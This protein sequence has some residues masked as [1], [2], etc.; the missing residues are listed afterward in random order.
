MSAVRKGKKLFGRKYYNKG[1]FGKRWSE[2]TKKQ[3]RQLNEFDIE[4]IKAALLK[5]PRYQKVA[6][7]K[8]TK[9]K[10]DSKKFQKYKTRGL[11][12]I[13]ERGSEIWVGKKQI[14]DAIFKP[15]KKSKTSH[16]ALLNQAFRQLVADEVK[17]IRTKKLRM[18][19]A[20]DGHL[21]PLSGV[22]L[23]ECEG[24][25]DLDHVYPFSKMV[26]DF[27]RKYRIIPERL[28]CKKVGTSVII[29]DENI[30]DLWIEYHNT[31][32]DLQLTCRKANIKKSNKVI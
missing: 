11:I 21:C 25:V 18:A 13:S 30:R 14:C 6:K 16:K 24:G 20:E 9:L 3:T 31:N 5:V 8:G 17:Q 32:A 1:E 19:F 10:I 4:F 29:T 15:K 23:R 12:I 28:D 22:E 2:I 26:L 7:E 27:Y